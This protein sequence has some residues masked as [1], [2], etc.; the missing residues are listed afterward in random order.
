MSSSHA[1][2]ETVATPAQVWSVLCDGYRYADWVHGTKEIRSVEDG[3]PR[4]GTSLHFTAGVGPLTFKDRTTS[5]TC[6]PG[7]FLELEAHAWPSGTAR[8]A[9]LIEKSDTGSRVTLEEY[10]LRGP[11]R[12]LHNPLSAFGFRMR[13]KLMIDDLLALAEAE[14]VG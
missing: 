5:L 8:V 1:T 4:Q 7:T 10:P 13:V 2:R 3:W 9:I 11:A 14:P 12:W 6:R